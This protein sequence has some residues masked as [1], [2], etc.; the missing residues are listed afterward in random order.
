MKVVLF[1]GGLGMRLREYS[2]AIP[3]PMVPIG[4]RP[5]L[6]HVMKY[7]ASFGHKDFILCLGHQAPAIKKYFVDY[8][9]TVSNDFVLQ[10]G[11]LKLLGSDIHDWTITF[12][13]TGVDTN[14][15]GRLRKVRKYVENE[16]MFLANY[17]DGLTDFQLPR[18]I[19]RVEDTDAALGFIAVKP[20]Y[21]FH[22]VDTDQAGS[23]TAV[24]DL[25]RADLR[26]NGGYF[27]M[28]PEVFDYMRKGEE[29]VNEPFQRMIEAGKVAAELYDGFWMS[30]DTFKE[31]Q[32]LDEMFSRDETPWQVWRKRHAGS[33][34]EAPSS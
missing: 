17:A 13:D 32:R 27:V 2:D 3:K 15:G 26:I 10:G 25:S 19:D 8:D 5:V 9:E 18:L 30:M 1:C 23:V 12:V 22:V 29:L 24:R 4:N 6:W 7:Y 16:E 33:V 21:S 14:I 28:R 20:P 34:E 31:K 11:D